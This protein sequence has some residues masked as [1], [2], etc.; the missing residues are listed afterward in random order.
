[1]KSNEVKEKKNEKKK[2]KKKCLA[3]ARPVLYYYPDSRKNL[4]YKALK[5]ATLPCILINAR[6]L[7]ISKVSE[8]ALRLPDNKL[9]GHGRFILEA[10]RSHTITHHSRNDSSG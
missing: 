9:M 4:I 8:Y 5:T 1:M 3:T 7:E 10:C 2:V 6:C